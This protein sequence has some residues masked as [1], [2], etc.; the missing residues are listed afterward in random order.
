MYGWIWRQ[1]PGGT[2][3]KLACALTAALAVVALL[4]FV[5][6]PWIT[7]MLPVDRVMPGGSSNGPCHASATHTRPRTC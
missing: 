2:G 7:P 4:W 6:F 3:S 1:F 5:V